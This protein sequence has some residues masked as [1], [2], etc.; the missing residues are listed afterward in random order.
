MCKNSYIPVHAVSD[1][2]KQIHA[3]EIQ[4][5]MMMVMMMMTGGRRQA[6]AAR[7]TK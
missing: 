6:A 5:Y 2:L 4:L 3:A 1:S 7:V